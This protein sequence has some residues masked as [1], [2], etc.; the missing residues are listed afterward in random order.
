MNHLA[1]HKHMIIFKIIFYFELKKKVFLDS[2]FKQR[3]VMII[4][5]FFVNE[6]WTLYFKKFLK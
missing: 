1:H 6:N 3:P 4:G 2:D 5:F